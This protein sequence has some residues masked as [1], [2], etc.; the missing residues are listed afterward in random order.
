MTR[1]DAGSTPE[2]RDSVLDPTLAPPVHAQFG[3]PGGPL[4]RSAP[5]YRGLLGGLGLL[6]AVGIAL[7]LVSLGWVVQIVLVGAFLAVGLN[8]IVEFLMR[9]CRLHRHWAVLVVGLSVVLVIVAVIVVLISA[10]RDQ[11]ESFINRAP[12]LLNSL[13]RQPTI[14][15]LDDKYHFI[16]DLQNRLDNPDTSSDQLG[17]IF[18]TGL[19]ALQ[20]GIRLFVSFVLM[21]Y[22]LSS[23]PSLKRALYSLAPVGRRSR[24]GQLGDEIVRRVGRYVIGAA[25]VALLAGTV[26]FIFLLS[27][28]LGEYALPL[29]LFVA[30]LDLVPLVGS[31]TGAALVTVVC[32]ATSAGTGIAALVFY[33]IY[34]TLEGYVIY[35]RVMRS[36]IDVPEYVTIIAVLAGGALG[37]IVGALLALPIAA[38]ILL[39]VREVWVASQDAK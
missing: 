19:S 21:L 16:T 27:V 9:R 32:F 34:E 6:T 18:S 22:F 17:N 15:H 14:R 10:L 35:P 24:V 4:S 28:G 25:V 1:A 12:E 33:V 13:R 30:L 7:A 11:V 31:V 37:G 8:P 36:S 3:V 39:I 20:V 26:T 5:F 29:A 23:L 2:H 38:A